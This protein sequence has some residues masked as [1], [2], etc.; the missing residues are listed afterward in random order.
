M[1]RFA[2]NLTTLFTESPFIDRFSAAAEAGFSGV[3]YLFPYA[4]SA[5]DLAD[6]LQAAGLQ[7]AL[8]NFPPGDWDAGD[9]GLAAIPGR[10]SE[11]NESIDVALDYARALACPTLHVMAGIPSANASREEAMEIY[12]DNLRR[13]ADRCAPEGI[14]VVIEP[15][16][17]RDMPK[18]LLSRTEEARQVIDRVGR[19]NLGLQLDFYHCQIMEG[20][21]ETRLR[22][23]AGIVRHV[24]IAGVPARHEPDTG[25]VNYPHLFRVMDEIGYD[26]WVGCEYHPR[27]GTLDGLGWLQA[28]NS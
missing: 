28:A 23:L 3:E 21:L 2:A 7:Q 12:V 9:R 11:F 16:N 20:D 26:G 22:D 17:S 6:R 13:A 14:T 5:D 19:E 4:F 27:A 24:Q 25:E 15:L 18:Y 10:Q 8:F 1:P